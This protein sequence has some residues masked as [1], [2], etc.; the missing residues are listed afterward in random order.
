MPSTIRF[1][2]KPDN[3]TD[4]VRIPKSQIKKSREILHIVNSQ[5]NEK[6]FFADKVILVE[7]ISDR[8]VFEKLI[9]TFSDN[10]KKNEVIEVLEVG[11][12]YY[13]QKYRDFLGVVKVK[14][15]IISDHDYLKDVGTP[16]IKKLYKA[17]DKKIKNDVLNSDKSQDKKTLV[18]FLDS[19]IKRC[20]KSGL[21]RIWEQIKDQKSS[22]KPNLTKE[23]LKLIS[24]FINEKAKDNLFILSD[25]QLEDYF[26]I[27]QHNLDL[28]LKFIKANNFN[29]WL[30]EKGNTKKQ[31][32]LKMIDT[33]VK[34]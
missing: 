26:P 11:N 23:E 30:K 14:N 25:G 32:I 31:E 5:N 1:Y 19:A 2:K 21:K 29:K 15:Y 27:G 22:L 28:V 6:M 12:K 10:N 16:D 13:L 17:D 34:A 3:S 9:N 33:I 24:E 20:D 8:L 7:G 4:L 18:K